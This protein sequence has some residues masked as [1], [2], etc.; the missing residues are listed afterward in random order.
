MAD[1]DRGHGRRL[2][3]ED[4]LPGF[5]RCEEN[6]RGIESRPFGGYSLDRKSDIL[7]CETFVYQSNMNPC[8]AIGRDSDL[9]LPD[10]DQKLTILPRLERI[11]ICHLF[12]GFL[13]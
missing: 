1:P 8:P 7:P 3:G 10:G 9:F 5:S 12:A 2:Q 6:D 11:E 4:D 13:S